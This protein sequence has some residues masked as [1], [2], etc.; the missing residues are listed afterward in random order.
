MIL[1]NG[2]YDRIKWCVITA[3]PALIALIQGLGLLYNFDTKLITGT[4][5]LVTTFVG[6]LIGVGSVKYKKQQEQQLSGDENGN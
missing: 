5:A 6:A 1:K 2:W 4:I 3:S